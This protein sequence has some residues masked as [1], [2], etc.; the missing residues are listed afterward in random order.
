MKLS[1]HI[2]KLASTPKGAFRVTPSLSVSRHASTSTST[3]ASTASTTTASKDLTSTFV[4]DQTPHLTT[5]ESV[6][7]PLPKISNS[8][9]F[10]SSLPPN[11]PTPKASERENDALLELQGLIAL[12]PSFRTEI[13]SAKIWQKYISLSPS[14]RRSLPIDFLQ[15]VFQY[16]I[17]NRKH[18]KDLSSLPELENPKDVSISKGSVLRER[19][20]HHSSLGSKWERRLR[21]IA[22]DILSSPLS[23]TIDPQIFINGLS[24]LAMVG[25]K[26]GCESIIREVII[27]YED[28]LTFR[29]SRIMY[30][31]GLR[32]VSK[33]LKIHG[34]RFRTNQ[35]EIQEAAETSKRLIRS[36]QEK[37]VKPNSTTAENL[38]NISRLVSS[39]SNDQE[40]IKSFDNLTE[41][42]L[43]NGYSLDL[44][45]LSFESEEKISQLKPSVKLAIIDLL[46]RK[47]KLYEMVAA[48]ESLFPGDI[49]RLP[50]R[51]TDDS[52]LG[53]GEEEE[54]IPTLSR[55]IAAEQAERAERGWF[56]VRTVREDESSDISSSL[57]DDQPGPQPRQFND[58]LPPIPT[59]YEIIHPS[60]LSSS[61]SLHTSIL[62]NIQSSSSTSNSNWGVDGEGAI[63]S[64]IFSMLSRAWQSKIKTSSNDTVY[65]DIAIHTLRIALRAAHTEQS[66]FVYALKEGSEVIPNGPALRIEENW[67]KAVWRIVRWTRSTSRRGTKFSKIILEELQDV[68]QRIEQERVILSSLLSSPADQSELP[69]APSNPI[70]AIDIPRIIEEIEKLQLSLAQVEETI[71]TNVGIAIERKAR[72]NSARL[73]KLEERKEA[74]LPNKGRKKGG[75]SGNLMS[76]NKVERDEKSWA[77]EGAPVIA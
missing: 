60:A 39:T 61:S 26:Q 47:G 24:K 13:G 2:Q 38:L 59:P 76:I 64:S 65:K 66:R 48:F 7:K 31:Y 46:G 27:R 21:T 14:F 69:E 49:D 28:K 18:V 5:T 16:V 63:V 36:M 51:S 30:G 9:F 1:L 74:L 11:F 42:I 62:H 34:H 23:K 45:N 77:G 73:V 20:K 19:L 3:S 4:R 70:L 71:Q 15:K 41:A 68:K 10:N 33:W 35:S 43:T 44:A 55:L 32:S 57:L 29:Q 52:I 67:F 6:S 75:L 22:S 25:D 58:Y 37:N 12:P 17:P 72:S 8:D 50:N 56:G 54:E 53:R 40:S